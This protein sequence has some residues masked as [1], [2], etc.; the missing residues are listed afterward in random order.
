MEGMTMAIEHLESRSCIY[1]NSSDS[2]HSPLPFG[3]GTGV[4]SQRD[5][6]ALL[7]TSPPLSAPPLF[8]FPPAAGNTR[9][10]EYPPSAA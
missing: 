10:A 2:K 7:F 9:P 1:R 6:V 8:S 3:E 4:G 5:G